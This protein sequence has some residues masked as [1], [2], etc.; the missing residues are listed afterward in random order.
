M[1]RET[2]TVVVG[3]ALAHHEQGHLRHRG[4]VPRGAHR[5]S[6]AHHWRD[7]A[8]EHLHHRQRDLRADAGVATRE[9]VDAAGYRR[10]HDVARGGL[11]DAGGVVVDQ[12]ALELRD[13]LVAEHD[14]GELADAGVG[15]VH[16]LVGRE[17]LFEHPATAADALERNRVQRDRFAVASNGRK[18]LDGQRLPVKDDGHETLL[19]LAARRRDENR[20]AVLTL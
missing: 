13:L 4:E 10:A 11:A 17:L 6:L 15:A 19:P 2:L 18:L 12:G 16:D 20:S 5:A 8:V 3:F 1:P 9:H 14:L 7:A